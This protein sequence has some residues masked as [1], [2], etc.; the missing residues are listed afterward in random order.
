MRTRILVGSVVTIF[1]LL[2]AQSVSAVQYTTV[3]QTNASPV[4]EKTSRHEADK[5][6]EKSI[7]LNLINLAEKSPTGSS[8]PLLRFLFGAL[9]SLGDWFFLIFYWVFFGIPNPY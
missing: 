6:L 9:I 4:H 3:T 8:F 5:S 7:E 1:L 2:L